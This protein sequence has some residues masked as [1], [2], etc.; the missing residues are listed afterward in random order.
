MNIK[1]EEKHLADI[2]TGAAGPG[3]RFLEVGSWDGG[4]AAILGRIAKAH[5]G[6]LVCVDWWKGSP[7]TALWGQDQHR[8]VYSEF[9]ARI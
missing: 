6:S 1:L 5:G 9:W 2:A 7:G 3:C 8:D 4:S